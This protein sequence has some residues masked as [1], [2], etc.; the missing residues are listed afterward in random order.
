MTDASLRSPGYRERVNAAT[1]TAPPVI[2]GVEWVRPGPT[3]T[4]RRRDL[5]LALVLFAA[6]LT[7]SLLYRGAG[8]ADEAP[9]WHS[10]IWAATMN[11]KLAMVL[12]R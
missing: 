12:A 10:A 11:R 8:V 7:S 2:D 3:P 1:S 4:Q 5:L 9:Y 6:T